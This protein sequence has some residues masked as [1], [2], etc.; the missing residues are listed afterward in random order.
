MGTDPSSASAWPRCR[1]SATAAAPSSTSAR[2]GVGPQDVHRVIVLE[3]G[4]VGFDGDADAGI[5]GTSRYDGSDTE[6][7]AGL[8]ELDEEMGADI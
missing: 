8:R 7:G 1:R 5:K 6:G 3:H 2:D 4:R